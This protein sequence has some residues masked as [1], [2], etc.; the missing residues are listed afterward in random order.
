[1]IVKL[2]AV[3][4]AGKKHPLMLLAPE[5][6]NTFITGQH[7]DPKDPLTTNNLTTDEMLGKVSLSE[8]KRKKFPYV[9]NPVEP[10]QFFDGQKFDTDVDKDN[11]ML[12]FIKSAGKFKVAKSKSDFSR[13][14][15]THYLENKEEEARIEVQDF[16]N[17]F[18]AAQYIKNSNEDE[19]CN[20][21]M[22]LNYIIPGTNIDLKSFTRTRI[23]A[24]MYKL[25]QKSP[26]KVIDAYSP[27][28]K[29][30][31]YIL[32]LVRH[33]ILQHKENGFYDGFSYIGNNIEAVRDFVKRKD[34][35]HIMDRW[36]RE[37]LIRTGKISKKEDPAELAKKYLDDAKIAI[38]DG[39]FDL[40]AKSITQAEKIYPQHQD[41]PALKKRMAVSIEKPEAPKES[42]EP[43]KAFDESSLSESQSL[44]YNEIKNKELDDLV[45]LAVIKKIGPKTK[46]SKLSRED[47]LQQLLTKVK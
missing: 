8:E 15:H 18:I 35:V 27:E 31:V 6:N 14:K 1:M 3:S 21:A 23:L 5:W 12:G 16:D 36:G 26:S 37:L 46:V 25:C 39:N 22:Y 4:K 45:N 32:S 11:A 38:M 20:A 30:D 24:E 9:I 29:E 33:E 40:A 10:L 47:I 17:T 2:V 43:E 28:R 34:N 13:Q 19:L 42:S 44:F 7:I 41:I